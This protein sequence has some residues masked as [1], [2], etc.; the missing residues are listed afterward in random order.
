MQYQGILA[1][2]MYVLVSSFFISGVTLED[3]LVLG[4]WCGAG[5]PFKVYFEIYLK[6]IFKY[7]LKTLVSVEAT[8]KR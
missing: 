2:N 6:H 3:Q 5:V 8:N 4:A 7:I 1:W